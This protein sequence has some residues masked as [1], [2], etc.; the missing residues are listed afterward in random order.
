MS[1]TAIAKSSAV[2]GVENRRTS[3]LADMLLLGCAALILALGSATAIAA[4]NLDINC[5]ESS[6]LNPGSD[7]ETVLDIDVVDLTTSATADMQELRTPARAVP[8]DETN[9]PHLYLGP[10][11]ATIVRDVFGE[12][13]STASDELTDTPELTPT[14]QLS[15]LAE[16]AEPSSEQPEDSDMSI[17]EAGYS[18][19]RIHREMYRTDI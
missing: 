9:A 13:E 2:K 16:R 1:L 8:G 11:V 18:P 12:E 17:E 14:T 4:S 7:P 19:L 10:R 3:M 5:M 6:A 15:P